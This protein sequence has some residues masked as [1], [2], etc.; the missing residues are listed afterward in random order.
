MK[1]CMKVFP[2]LVPVVQVHKSIK[3]RGVQKYII[4]IYIFIYFLFNTMSN[5]VSPFYAIAYLFIYLFIMYL[6][7]LQLQF[8]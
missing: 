2:I 1:F 3:H 4:I 7:Y 5:Y 6:L 8:F